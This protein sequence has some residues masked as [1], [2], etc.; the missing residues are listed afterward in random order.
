MFQAYDQHGNLITIYQESISKIEKLK[1]ESLFYCPACKEVLLIRYGQKVTP[2]FA[3]FPTST[4]EIKQRGES[5]YH[6]TGKWLLYR[7]LQG[8][9]YDV[10]V[11]PYLQEIK[12]R[13]DLLLNHNNK[14]AA[15]EFQCASIP[16]KEVLKR[17]QGYHQE[18]V[19]PLWI[20]GRN[21][22]KRK[23]KQVL[24]LE[25]FHKA[26][27]YSFQNQYCMYFFDVNAQ[28]MI[29]TQQLLGSSSGTTFAVFKDFPMKTTPF[30]RLFN[31]SHSSLHPFYSVWEKKVYQF[32]TLYKPQAGS[33]ERQWRQLIYLHGFHFTLI[34][35]VCYIPVKSQ[36][37]C[38]EAPYVWQTRFLLEYYMP[39]AIGE[40][41]TF[42]HKFL[43]SS[44]NDKAG[45]SLYEEYLFQLNHQ[46]YVRRSVNGQWVKKKEIVF[47]NHVE[48]A[49]KED[50]KVLIRLKHNNLL[51]QQEFYDQSRI[52]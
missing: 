52:D 23:R 32:R 50:R 21:Q 25:Q 15:I 31:P 13:P 9:G 43:N 41:I 14:R 39:K 46:G 44:V 4:C 49:V 20:L 30:S 5:N 7:W 45:I 12:Q 38:S 18:G 37:F 35:S 3:H 6:A 29:M 24:Q 34:P 36:L 27:I 17:T 16:M 48:E 19:F 33:V 8:Q 10:A 40:V 1:N 28:S 51:D 42:P 26:M 47:H 2:H 22:L 11:E